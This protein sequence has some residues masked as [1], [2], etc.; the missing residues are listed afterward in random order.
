MEREE[1]SKNKT[2]G[3]RGRSFMKWVRD[4]DLYFVNES[5][6]G[7]WKGEYGRVQQFGYRLWLYITILT[8]T[9]QNIF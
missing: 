7:D 8:L 3:N 2:V 5:T 1:S 6:L 4:K 9:C